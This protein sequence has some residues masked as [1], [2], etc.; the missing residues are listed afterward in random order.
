MD[1]KVMTLENLNS[2][3]VTELFDEEF[4]KLLKNIADDNTEPDKVRSITIK[5]MVKPSKDRSK[6]DTRVAVTSILAPLK[7]HESYILLE[8]NGS[9]L[10]AYT[11]DVKQPEL[12]DNER[13]FPE[14][15]KG[16]A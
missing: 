2:G 5:L 15:K 7:P 16:G 9:R 12:G 10:A 1:Y 6:A 13:L 4:S 8:N 11:T 3:A 14:V